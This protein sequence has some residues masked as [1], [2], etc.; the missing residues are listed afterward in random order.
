MKR[1]IFLILLSLS[2]TACSSSPKVEIIEPETEITT[3][4]S[5]DVEGFTIAEQDSNTIILIDDNDVTLSIYRDILMT[6]DTRVTKNFII[7]KGYS[8]I[9]TDKHECYAY[10]P[11]NG[12]EIIGCW[13]KDVN[14]QYWTYEMIYPSDMRDKYQDIFL[15]YVNN[16]DVKGA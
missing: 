16:I 12:F 13:I 5:Y 4:N 14:D 1:F 15:G 3:E 8:Y 10:S 7:T 2:L 6:S 11:F 9:P